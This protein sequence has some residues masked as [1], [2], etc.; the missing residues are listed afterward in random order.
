MLKNRYVQRILG[1]G[2][3]ERMGI[4]FLAQS[5]LIRLSSHKKADVV[6]F[7]RKIR[8][9]R[10]SLV[11]GFEAYNVY[12]LARSTQSLKGDIAE[13]GVFQGSTARIICELK[14]DRKVRLFDTF[15]GLPKSSDE[16]RGVHRE[17]QYACSLESVSEYLKDFD[18]V[19]YHKGLFPESVSDVED[20]SYSFVH[21]DVDLYGG[22]LACLEYFYPKMVPGGIMLSHDYSILQGVE[23]AFTEFL[24]DKPESIIELA[25]TQCMVIKL[26]AAES[27]LETKKLA[28]QVAS[29]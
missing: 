25:T 21:F 26:P 6:Q 24:D 14:G 8:R 7:L 23:Q 15:E 2:I 20:A 19:T 13:V 9:E 10:R 28:D 12:A 11:T 3:L 22:T 18:N 27:P 16:D 1:G 29:N 17:K 5:D 4:G